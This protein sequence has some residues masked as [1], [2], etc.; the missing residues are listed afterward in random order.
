MGRLS[1]G[2]GYLR[3][4]G[5]GKRIK[6]YQ[7]GEYRGVGGRAG[8]DK[9]WRNGNFRNGMADEPRFAARGA[10]VNDRRVDPKEK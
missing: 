10:G 2:R 4:G 9:E 3:D 5:D 6:V 8:M 7:R 1:G